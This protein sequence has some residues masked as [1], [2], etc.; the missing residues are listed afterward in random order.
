M[1]AKWLP[2]IEKSAG[3]S[4]PGAGGLACIGDAVPRPHASRKP[5]KW[6]ITF[7]NAHLHS[8]LEHPRTAVTIASVPD[9]DRTAVE[10][11]N[12]CLVPRTRLKILLNARRNIGVSAFPSKQ[13]VQ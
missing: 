7:R 6:K 10:L 11:V 3:L 2:F 9:P 4:R 13:R 12:E 1:K 5:E 8:P